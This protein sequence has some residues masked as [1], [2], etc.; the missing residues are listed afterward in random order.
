MRRTLMI[1]LLLVLSVGIPVRPLLAQEASVCKFTPAEVTLL[2]TALQRLI[3]TN[4]VSGFPTMVSDRTEPQY[5][6]AQFAVV[7]VTGLGLRDEAENY[8]GEPSFPDLRGHW[9]VGAV[10]VLHRQGIVVGYPGG[11]F[12]PD[13]KVTLPQVKLML[14][15]A[16][17]LGSDL[18][19][20]NADMALRQ[21]GVDTSVPCSTDPWASAGQVYLLLD[22]TLSVPFYARLSGQPR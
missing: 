20:E 17:R 19:L 9:A 2:E 4:V 8:A 15:R 7:L 21:G 18:T 16:L 6:R 10:E 13:D 14:A 5:F 1:V 3:L 22:R 12:G 11:A